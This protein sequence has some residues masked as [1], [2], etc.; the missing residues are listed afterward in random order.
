M[1]FG[2]MSAE[3]CWDLAKSLNLDLTDKQK[4]EIYD[5]IHKVKNYKDESRGGLPPCMNYKYILQK[6]LD[7]LQIKYDLGVRDFLKN[8]YKDKWDDISEF[9]GW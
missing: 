7:S 5:R 6:I 4:Q 1:C 2:S 8:K 9:Y 3:G